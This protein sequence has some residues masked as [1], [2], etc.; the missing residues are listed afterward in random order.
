MLLSVKNLSK[1]FGDFTAV[2][3]VSFGI[4]RGQIV[5]LLGPN[6]AGKTTTIHMVLGLVTPTGGS[7]EIFGMPLAT[8]REAILERTNFTSPYVAFP[9]RLTVIENMRVFALIY[10]IKNPA[11]KITEMLEMLGVADLRDRPITRL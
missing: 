7:V 4:K 11:K 1:R 2:E 8:H 10:G 6:G 9:Y 3:N 5:G